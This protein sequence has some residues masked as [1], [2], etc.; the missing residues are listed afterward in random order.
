LLAECY[1][2]L[3]PILVQRGSM[4]VIDGMHRLRVAPR[5][6]EDTVRVQFFHGSVTAA[7]IAA[8]RLNAAHGPSR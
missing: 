3:P 1:T 6:G 2:E 8:V 7:F 4:Q 5:R